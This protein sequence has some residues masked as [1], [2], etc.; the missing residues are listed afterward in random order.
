MSLLYISW[1]NLKANKLTTLL[2]ILL[3][4]FG[5][6]I[7]SILLLASF[8]IESKL[9]KNARD[10]DLVV[11]AKGS[12]LQLILSNIFYIDFPTGNIPLKDAQKLASHPMVSRAVPLALG[13]NYKGFRIAGTDT[14]FIS[15][16]GLQIAEGKFWI[17]DF[18]V[19]VGSQVAQVEK[20]KIGDKLF[21]AH[22]LTNANEKHES[23]SYVVSGILKAQGNVTDNL[24]LTNI[25]SVWK[26]HDIQD[27]GAESK[28]QIVQTH[29]PEITSL[30]IQ[31]N[32]P[33][34]AVV[35]PKMV[36]KSTNLQ[37]ASPAIETARLFSLIGV[38]VDTL[39]WFALLIMGISAIS[40]FISLYNSMKERKY[41]LA[42]M[43]TIGAS[44]LKLFQTVILEGIILTLIGA[45]LGVIFGHLAI[46]IIGQYQDSN[47]AR[48]SGTIFL[49][50][51]LFIIIIGIGI[52]VIAAL[53]PAVQAYRSDI[54][55]ILSK[56]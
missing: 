1:N 22:G 8:Q 40:V 28:Q 50:K 23:H 26:M 10:I 25:S 15:L 19:T 44:K 45:D 24:V 3:I 27:Q 37:A 18:E 12:P 33:V 6:G 11:G 41:D 32:S 5:T 7:L 43:R 30:L 29:E 53:I 49:E 34:S 2:N 52:G 16:Y 51:E 20:L 55:Q 42:V 56:N 36:N 21:G 9:E 35:F 17:G 47:Q 14:N 54:S 31:Y 13:D 4:S 46:H 48:L 39:E 38:G